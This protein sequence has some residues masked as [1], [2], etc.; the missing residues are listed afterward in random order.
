[1]PTR[2]ITYHEPRLKRYVLMSPLRNEADALD[3]FGPAAYQSAYNHTSASGNSSNPNSPGSVISLEGGEGAVLRTAI[4]TAGLMRHHVQYS[5][6]THLS[7]SSASGIG[8]PKKRLQVLSVE[9]NSINRKVLAAFF[10]KMDVDLVEATNGE[11]GVR[12]F[13]AYG[14]FH[15]DVIF[16]DLSM[17]VLDGIGA[18]TQIRKIEAERFKN[19]QSNTMAWVKNSRAVANSAGSQTNSI[20]TSSAA[21][22][23]LLGTPGGSR[24][25][26][27]AR[28][29]IFALTGRS[30]DEDKRRAFA[31]G[32]DGFI[33]KPLSYKVLTSLIHTISA[34]K[35][36]VPA[37]ASQTNQPS[38]MS[39]YQKS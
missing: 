14:P 23:T 21:P 13:E 19:E 39:K 5:G 8:G 4:H 12:T 28:S 33:V 36:T 11:E 20:S 32:A 25:S 34:Y 3:Y 2:S 7:T 1:M 16:M 9:D 30:S 35:N 27:Q 37:S 15:F 38:H 18:M 10:A 6:N 26:A 29:K 31:M 22:A 17:P 24:P